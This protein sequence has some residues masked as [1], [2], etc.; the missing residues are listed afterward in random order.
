MDGVSR[1]N[2]GCEED[3]LKVKHF[4]LYFKNGLLLQRFSLYVGV[5]W[6]TETQNRKNIFTKYYYSLLK[7]KR[8]MHL[9]RLYQVSGL[10]SAFQVL[11][12]FW[13]WS[14]VA[15]LSWDGQ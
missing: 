10:I 6:K 9:P 2:S 11:Y 12:H 7:K 1:C 4:G 13:D 15:W 8:K 5:K 3:Q 14:Q